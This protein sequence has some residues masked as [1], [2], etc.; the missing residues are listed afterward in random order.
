MQLATDTV[1]FATGQLGMVELALSYLNDR[2]KQYYSKA[3]M[4]EYINQAQL[5]LANIINRIHK[6]YFL[7]SATSPV[8]QD[9]SYYSF[10]AD[11]VKLFGL[12][13]GDN[14]TDQDPK[15]LVEVPITDRYFYQQL[16]DANDKQEYD[17]FFISGTTFKLMPRGG[18]VDNEQ[19]RVHYVKR[20]ERLSDNADVS[21]IPEEHH[22]T[23]VLDAVRRAF[24]KNNRVNPTLEK[25]WNEA[26]ESMR[27]AI[28]EYSPSGEWRVKPWY[29]TYGPGRDL[30]EYW[31]GQEV[32]P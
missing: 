26:L 27:A 9:Q 6:T 20:L 3:E 10:P 8:V 13:V 12:E 17:F 11:M 14:T 24:V 4:I 32:K 30:W 25:M 7:T 18:S 28:A 31:I 29:G 2:N 15:R 5:K 16:D 22:E 19:M 21:E 23:I 1:D